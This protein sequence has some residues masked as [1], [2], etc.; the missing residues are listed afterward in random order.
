MRQDTNAGQRYSFKTPQENKSVRQFINLNAT[1]K[2]DAYRGVRAEIHVAQDD[3]KWNDIQSNTTLSGDVYD[4][5]L[6]QATNNRRGVDRS[7]VLPEE[8]WQQLVEA[9]EIVEGDPYEYLNRDTGEVERGQSMYLAFESDVITTHM[10]SKPDVK[11]AKPMSDPLDIERHT[12]LTDM[13]QNE[14]QPLYEAQLIKMRQSDPAFFGIEPDKT[15]EKEADTTK[16][17]D[18]EL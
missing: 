3:K 15:V 1:Q 14:N 16:D 12:K 4:P 7:T 9:G 8:E 6:A 18:L 2:T 11:T 10:T 5:Q 17:D 13:K